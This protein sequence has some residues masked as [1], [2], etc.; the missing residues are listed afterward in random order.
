MLQFNNS[1]NTK[2]IRRHSRDRIIL[3]NQ[4]GRLFFL[5]IITLFCVVIFTSCNSRTPSRIT[6]KWFNAVAKKDYKTAAS[7]SY[8]YEKGFTD[9]LKA[10]LIEERMNNAVIWKYKVKD[11]IISIGGENAVV[12][13]KVIIDEIVKEIDV[14]EIDKWMDVK[15]FLIKTEIDGWKIDIKRTL[16]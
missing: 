4:I 5:S 10:K 14:K 12:T 6:D 15:I 1:N 3:K 16:E 11:E 7:Y 13:V 9:E 8:F 2:E